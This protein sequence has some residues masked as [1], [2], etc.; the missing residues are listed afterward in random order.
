M[1][2]LSKKI[3]KAGENTFFCITSKEHPLLYLRFRGTV[4]HVISSSDKIRYYIEATEILETDDV[5]KQFVHNKS[6]RVSKSKHR[7]STSYVFHKRFRILDVIDGNDISTA[8]CKKYNNLL[9]RVP[10]SLTF[11]TLEELNNTVDDINKKLIQD[12]QTEL[13]HVKTLSD[14]I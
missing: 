5:V 14:R 7:N 9:F 10:I 12:I 2:I 8:V 6:F 13:L 11:E 3:L 1:D 4:R